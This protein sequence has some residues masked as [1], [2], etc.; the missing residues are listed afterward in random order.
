[1]VLQING[2]DGRK[3]DFVPFENNEF[4]WWV[5]VRAKDLG[6]PGEQISVY[7]VTT[8]NGNDA[9]GMTKREYLEKRGKCS[10]GFG[11]VCAWELV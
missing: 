5:D 9:R 6:A 7:A 1:M 8:I 4:W 10:T 2:V 11:G 3:K